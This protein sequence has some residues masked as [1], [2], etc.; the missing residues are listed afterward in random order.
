MFTADCC[1]K[2]R[3]EILVFHIRRFG[4]VL[5]ELSSFG[6]AM[7]FPLSCGLFCT[8]RR[9]PS[10]RHHGIEL[11]SLL[12]FHETSQVQKLLPESSSISP[13][14]TKHVDSLRV[15]EVLRA[16]RAQTSPKLQSPETGFDTIS[17]NSPRERLAVDL[18]LFLD[19]H[20]FRGEMP[21]LTRRRSSMSQLS[22]KEV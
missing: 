8:S 3:P 22:H 4:C 11:G 1:E 20:V 2:E 21:P 15:L 6:L 14:W 5:L 10:S 13:S 17:S 18:D 7:K 9:P 19:F 16:R 12:E